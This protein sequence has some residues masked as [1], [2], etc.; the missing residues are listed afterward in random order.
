MKDYQK[1]ILIGSPID[2]EREVDPEPGGKISKVM[3]RRDWGKMVWKI[4]NSFA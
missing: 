2:E 3:S 1:D 4:R